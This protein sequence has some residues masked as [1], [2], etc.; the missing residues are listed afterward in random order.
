LPATPGPGDDLAG[1]DPCSLL[2]SSVD[3]MFGPDAVREQG[4]STLALG[5]PA[6]SCTLVTPAPFSPGTHHASLTLYPRSVSA[7]S[8]ALLALSVF[9]GGLIEDT[10]AGRSVW[11]NECLAA[12][13]P[14]TGA[15]AAWSDPYFIVIEFDR[16]SWGEPSTTSLAT[17]RSVLEAVLSGRSN[18]RSP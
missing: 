18:R 6:Q 3:K 15:L 10:V 1:I 17:A 2:P 5:V 4:A 13:L 8:A 16:S 7:E 9:G 14:C 11:I 12:T